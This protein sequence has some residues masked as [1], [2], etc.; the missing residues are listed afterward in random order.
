MFFAE[1]SNFFQFFSSPYSSHR[2]VRTAENKHFCFIRHNRFQMCKV[3]LITA[4]FQYQRAFHYFT[5]ILYNSLIQRTIGRSIDDHFI[6]FFGKCFHTD[7]G[8]NIDTGTKYNLLSGYL[9]LMLLSHP[10]PDIFIESVA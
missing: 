4:V 3:D 7:T 9:S 5:V 2:I 10:F 6:H 8:R 1:C